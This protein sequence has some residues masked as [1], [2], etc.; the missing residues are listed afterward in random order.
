MTATKDKFDQ[1]LRDAHAWLKDEATSGTRVHQV[2]PLDPKTLRLTL[3]MTQTDFAE[4]FLIPVSTLRGWEQGRRFPD[5]TTTAY[6][7]L[8]ASSPE[9]AREA[10]RAARSG[11]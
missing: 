4:T 9:R 10:L 5:A 7:T 1:G 2:K 6:L 8:I 11:T 3:Q